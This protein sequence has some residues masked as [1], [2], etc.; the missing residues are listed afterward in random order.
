MFM[1]D[2]ILIYYIIIYIF[3]LFHSNYFYK[4]WVKISS[5]K[6]LWFSRNLVSIVV[7]HGK[8]K[9]WVNGK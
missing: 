1:F 2:K 4:Q 9:F 3:S 7:Q 8:L 6:L 5:D